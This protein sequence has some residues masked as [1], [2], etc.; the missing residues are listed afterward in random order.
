MT[1]QEYIKAI[2]MRHSRR[3]YKSRPL[4]QEVMGVVKEMVDAVNEAANLDFIFI[5]DA[6]P[7]FKIFTGKFSMIV[8]CGPDSQKA[9]E[10]CG[11]YGES[12]V[13]QCV[14]HGLGT[15]WV[16][17]T[18]NENK[19]YEM[20]DLP[21]DKR[22]YAV[23]T[24]G[25]AKERYTVIEKTMYNAT[26]KKSKPYQKMFDVCDKKLPDEYAYAMKL[27]EM[28]PSAVNRRPVHFKYENDV[29]SAFVDEPYSDKSVD[30]GIAKL[31]FTLGCR[32]KG[33]N[34][35]WTFENT[36]EVVEPQ[37]IKFEPKTEEQENE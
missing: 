10:D 1:N 21:R 28:G 4:S 11:Y 29:I 30:F 14:Y 8:V 15:C 13:L 24:I 19:V 32:A 18:Y 33:I 23:I 7:A 20:I 26:H 2:E 31:H 36:F 12:I 17:G 6:T 9:R 27:V 35:H 16:S 34:G 25:H 5:E 37:R 3:S 22:I